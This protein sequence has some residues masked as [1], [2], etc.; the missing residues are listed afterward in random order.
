[1]KVIEK[2]C[3][4]KT[5][6]SV[7]LPWLSIVTVSIIL[8]AVMWQRAGA[9][10]NGVFYAVV[11]SSLLSSV[12]SVFY[13]KLPL[14]IAPSLGMNGFLCYELVINR[15][16]SWQSAMTLLAIAGFVCIILKC[17]GILKCFS[18]CMPE[19]LCWAVPAGLGSMMVYRGLF[20][21]GL[22]ISSPFQ[23]TSMGQIT[24]PLVQI[25][26]LSLAL[27]VILL[28]NNKSY[29]LLAGLALAGSI[30]F[31]KGY[32]SL[33]EGLF[34][35]P[36]GLIDTICQLNLT[37]IN[38][39]W[40]DAVAL[41]IV[42]VIEGVA[43]EKGLQKTADGL[44]GQLTAVNGMSGLAGGLLGGGAAHIS[45]VM[46]AVP[47]KD[48]NLRQCVMVFSLGL[49]ILLFCGPLLLSMA[50]QTF[51][52]ASALTGAGLLILKNLKF[53]PISDKISYLAGCFSILLM[54]FWGS[55]TAG[56]C[57]GLSLYSFMLLASG[58]AR[59]QAVWVHVPGLVLMIHIILNI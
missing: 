38:C 20:E 43:L 36:E 52:T 24:D 19:Y 47:D 48:V 2:L 44:F 27:I 28:A 46:L 6:I 22:I 1:M 29:G 45:P 40:G 14:V 55:I 4:Y 16:N 9:P 54:V 5:S 10:Y 33:P 41:L 7:G 56:I 37:N 23:M 50:E 30:S 59:E 32:F 26:L 31:F 39:L 15:G 13:F 8:S 57:L 21:A 17:F 11:L 34:S 42:M 53:S 25:F 18:R 12:I 3:Q 58:R 49:L 35:V 51:I